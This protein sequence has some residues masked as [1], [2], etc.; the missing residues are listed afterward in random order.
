MR[1]LFL[2]VAF[3]L[4]SGITLLAAQ[5]LDDLPAAVAIHSEVKKN[6]PQAAAFSRYL[7]GF[8]DNSKNYRTYNLDL[9]VA[10]GQGQDFWLQQATAHQAGAL[11]LVRV[12]DFT[13]D[14][15]FGRLHLRLLATADKSL[16]KAWS[17]PIEP[18]AFAA[19]PHSRPYG[20]LDQVF[21]TWPVQHYPVSIERRVLLVS[22]QRLRG[23]GR[24]T[25]AF[26][27]NQL[28]LASRILER[29]FGLRLILQEVQRWRPPDIALDGIAKAASLIPNRET[30][31]LTLVC[32]GTPS[33]KT[34]RPGARAVG[35]A[36]V[37]TNTVVT[38]Q[39]SAHV[40][41][42]EIGHV[43]GA[44][45]VADED[46]IMQPYLAHHTLFDRYRVQPPIAFSPTNREIIAT[47]CALPLGTGY[48]QHRD[49][50]AGLLQIYQRL[51]PSHLPQVAPYYADVLLQQ[52]QLEQALALLRDAVDQAPNDYHIRLRLI[53]ALR[54][55]SLHAEA[56]ELVQQDLA[57]NQALVDPAAQRPT[58]RLST[59]RIAF[60][61][62]APG[63]SYTH[64]LTLSNWGTAPLEI[65]RI[66]AP[67][68][69]FSLAA[70]TP[71]QL[72]LEPGAFTN[73]EIGFSPREAGLYKSVLEL[74]CNVPGKARI[75]VQLSGRAND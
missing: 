42:H 56:H 51:R 3:L 71:L 35:Y 72:T 34:L 48:Y 37:L 11:L 12:E 39:L 26:L 8:L 62:S 55:A 33:V 67:E 73:L 44:I 29:E 64:T 50:I 15:P 41:V 19:S 6:G 28:A 10:N 49:K 69:P 32:L 38:N 22:D 61:H 1:R 40:F 47:T 5:P 27:E 75:T 46:A 59:T 54:Q 36:R 7:A 57:Q 23:S 52:G 30:A 20:N 63:R 58:I 60:D 17:A 24:A 2:L 16:L 74:A 14:D 66:T 45:H 31:D 65:S 21:A 43:L 70:E 68:A 25:R 4:S 13:A 53:Q 9:E 18:P